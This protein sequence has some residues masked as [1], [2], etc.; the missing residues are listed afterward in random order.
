MEHIEQHITCSSNILEN[1]KAFSFSEFFFSSSFRL[2]LTQAKTSEAPSDFFFTLSS[3]NLRNDKNV[4]INIV[5]ITSNT[6]I[7]TNI[8]NFIEDWELINAIGYIAPGRNEK[9]QCPTKFIWKN[10]VHRLQN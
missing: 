3:F 9:Q 4:K 1:C 5:H 8:R 10:N 7:E 6:D 2:L